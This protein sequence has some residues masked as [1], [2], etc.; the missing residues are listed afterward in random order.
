MQFNKKFIII[1]LVLTLGC[2]ISRGQDQTSQTDTISTHMQWLSF[3]CLQREGN[4]PVKATTALE[5]LDP[6]PIDLIFSSNEDGAYQFIRRT[7]DSWQ[8]VP[9]NTIRSTKGYKLNIAVKDKYKH[10]MYGSD[11]AID[12]PIPLYEQQNGNPENWIGYFLHQPLE[13]EDAF[14]GVWDKLTKIQTQHWTMI[15]L[16]TDGKWLRP[17]N[18]SPLTYGDM[19][20]V[21]VSKNCTLVWNADQSE[22]ALMLTERGEAEQFEYTEYDSYIPWFIQADSLPGVTEIGLMAGDTCIGA[23]AV[24]PGDTLV[25]VNAYP[26]AVSP[27]TPI[28]IV[29]VNGLKSTMPETLTGYLVGSID[30]VPQQHRKV[31]AGEGLPWYHITF[32]ETKP[33]KDQ[34]PEQVGRLLK[35]SPNPFTSATTIYFSVDRECHVEIQVA[36]LNGQAIATVTAGNFMPGAYQ[37]I[38]NESPGTVAEPKNGVYVVRLMID[39]KVVDHKKV[40]RIQ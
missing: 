6:M 29:T 1:F 22:E 18:V 24:M 5:N 32:G 34:A 10:T 36:G 2:E 9:F 26:Q 31:Y 20:I 14:K 15:R 39:Q 8:V 12:T 3:P 30:P 17:A 16:T 33:L 40:V 25:E 37:S 35:I 23:T 7:L 4:N 28:E 11:L 27:G 13:P 21:E 19:A 38:W